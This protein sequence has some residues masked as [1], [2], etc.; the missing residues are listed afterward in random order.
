MGS[1]AAL[2]QASHM[3]T[4]APAQGGLANLP[5]GTA[6]RLAMARGAAG[7]MQL[8]PLQAAMKAGLHNSVATGARP[9]VQLSAA[10]MQQIGAAAPM[11]LRPQHGLGGSFLPNGAALLGSQSTAVDL[12]APPGV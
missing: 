7:N 11:G 9:V 12:S 3:A 8:D 1:L 2:R 6:A 4:P 10:A 5:L